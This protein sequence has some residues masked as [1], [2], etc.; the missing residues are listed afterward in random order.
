MA[1]VSFFRN[2]FFKKINQD[3]IIGRPKKENVSTSSG[4]SKNIQ[5]Y[6]RD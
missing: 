6:A 5:N 2:I 1:G 4:E 3:A